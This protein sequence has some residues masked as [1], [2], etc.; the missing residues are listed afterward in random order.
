[1]EQLLVT[2][3]AEYK[4]LVGLYNTTAVKLNQIAALIKT[5]G[6]EADSVVVFKPEVLQQ[7]KEEIRDGLYPAGGDW[8]TKV[9]FTL[10]K[11]NEPLETNKIV[12]FLFYN[13][14]IK[15]RTNPNRRA[16][17]AGIISRMVKENKLVVDKTDLKPKYRLPINF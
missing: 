16:I 3:Y 9:I 10:K 12:E 6:G 7:I 1:M 11:F 15:F 5:Y 13:E 8:Q 17:I 14:T 4:S 2:L